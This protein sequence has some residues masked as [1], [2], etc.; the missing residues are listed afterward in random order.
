MSRRP[1]FDRSTRDLSSRQ[2]DRRFRASGRP[3]E[4]RA[5]VVGQQVVVVRL[6]RSTILLSGVVPSRAQFGVCL[7]S[8]Q[9]S[10]TR[11]VG[12]HFPSCLNPCFRCT[13][14]AG[15]V[16]VLNS[17]FTRR[18]IRKVKHFRAVLLH[19]LVGALS[20][21]VAVGTPSSSMA[22]SLRNGTSAYGS[23]DAQ[24]RAP[25]LRAQS[26]DEGA[27]LA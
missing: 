25:A 18:G 20:D 6:G 21:D 7:T 5:S 8:N 14:A 15:V 9:S 10:S 4:L 11:R 26:R 13:H 12:F 19:E 22:P 17:A 23:S 3:S 27:R 24:S 2:Q 1:L 16:P